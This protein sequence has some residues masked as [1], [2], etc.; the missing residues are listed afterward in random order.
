M[1]LHGNRFFTMWYGVLDPV[2]GRL[3]YSSA[4]HPPAL[5]IDPNATARRLTTKG[6]AVGCV[7]STTY[8]NLECCLETGDILYL[9]SDGAYEV[10]GSD[11][12]FISW[13]AFE[14][15]LTTKHQSPADS[16]DV[17]VSELGRI[18][19][20]SGFADDVSMMEIRRLE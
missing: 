6:I 17:I 4:G 11:G 10:R 5:V 13:E 1:S 7:A 12:H 3:V 20:D 15:L 18:A 16:L 2:S 19:G 14:N 8:E 9:F